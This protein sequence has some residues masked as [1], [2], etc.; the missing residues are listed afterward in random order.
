MANL[1][2]V[3]DTSGAITLGAIAA[4]ISPAANLGISLSELVGSGITD[5]NGDPTGIAI[6]GADN[7]NGTWQYSLNGGTTWIDF[8]SVSESS[9]LILGA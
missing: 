5:A 4:D 8:G 6:T 9:S 2:P 1:A 3:L 7:T